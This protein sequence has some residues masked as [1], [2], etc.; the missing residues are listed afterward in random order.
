MSAAC[1]EIAEDVD[2]ETIVSGTPALP[3]WQN[4]REQPALRRLPALLVQIR[5][6]EEEIARQS[7]R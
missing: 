6:L 2:P 4:L 1:S 5:K 7:T 3:H